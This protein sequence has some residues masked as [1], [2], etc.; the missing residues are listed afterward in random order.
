MQNPICLHGYVRK[1]ERCM[2]SAVF[3]L[4]N[5][6][7]AYRYCRKNGFLPTVYAGLERIQNK[8]VRYEKRILTQQEL[9]RQKNAEWK[10]KEY[11]SI[12]VPAYET[13]VKHFREMVDSVLSQTYSAFELII[14]DA[15]VS[16]KLQEVMK[17]YKDSRIR[18]MRLQENKGISEN[19]NAALAAARGSYIGLLDHDDVLEAD[20][21]YRMMEAIHAAGQTCKKAPGLLYSDEDKSNGDMSQYFDPHWKDEFNLDLILS[22]N[23]ICHFMVME[24]RLMKALRF[25]SAYDGAQDHDLALRAV[26]RLLFDRE[27]IVHVPYVLYHWRCHT[28]STAE[29]PG[30]KLYAYEAGRRAVED[31]CRRRGW[32]VQVVHTRHLGFFRVE[33]DGDILVQRPDLAAVGGRVVAA[34]KIV[35]GAYTKDGTA[36]YRGLSVHFSGYMHR[37]VLQQE[38]AAV[39]VRNIRVRPELLAELQA[40]CRKEQ[41]PV[42]ASMLFGRR[43]AQL[44]YRILWDPFF[45]TGNGATGFCGTH[46]AENAAGRNL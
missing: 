21:L 36:L 13:D 11:F 18:Y 15:S 16:D 45:T 17:Y 20:A 31:F 37:A 9:E 14:A 8:N 32:S 5:L 35:G 42:A 1:K 43:A 22:N 24:A 19:S 27:R 3:K 34:G 39:D 41:D 10:R 46:G 40:V 6:K 38:A 7:K 29:N 25:C 2:A 44:G 26:E 33:Y 12:L 23:Y 30:S 28:G 4:S